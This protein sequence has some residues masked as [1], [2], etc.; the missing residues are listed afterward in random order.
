MDEAVVDNV[1]SDTVEKE[2]V[3]FSVTGLDVSTVDSAV[4][5]SDGV[6][7][8]VVSGDPFSVVTDVD[9]SDS[10]VIIEVV[11]VDTEDNFV[12]TEGLVV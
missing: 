8:S 4:D 1:K 11:I 2:D 5:E 9:D 12:D 7:N 10:V 3:V 6:D